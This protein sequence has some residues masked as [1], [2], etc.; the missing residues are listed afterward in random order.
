MTDL[1]LLNPMWQLFA[2]ADLDRVHTVFLFRLN[3]CDLAPVDLDDCT[4]GQFAP[5]VP[6]VRHS[7]LVAH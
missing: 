1:R 5:F 3:L 2:N 7:Y 6:K 4:G